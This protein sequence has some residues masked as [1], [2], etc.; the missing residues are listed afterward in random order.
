MIYLTPPTTS[1]IE[2]IVNNPHIGAI[3]TP[4]SDR[5]ALYN[6]SHFRH[7]GADNGCFSSTSRFDDIRYMY[8]LLSLR[9]FAS[10]CLFATAPDVVGNHGKTWERSKPWLGAIRVLGF[11]AAFVAQ[12]GFDGDQ[13]VDW[14]MIDV[15]FVGGTTSYKLGDQA[16]Q[17]IR[18]AQDLGKKVHVGRVNSKRRVEIFNSLKVDSIDGTFLIFGPDT[19]LPALERWMHS[20]NNYRQEVFF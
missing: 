10:N 4:D 19:N 6:L 12:D 17:A 5:P 9:S 7:W 15:L 11:P 18:K 2:R 1:V 16:R 8:W 3:I 13:G 14:A 20:A